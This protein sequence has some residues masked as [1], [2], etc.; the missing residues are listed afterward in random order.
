MPGDAEC[1]FV[2]AFSWVSVSQSAVAH[3]FMR[4][5]VACMWVFWETGCPDI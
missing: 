3:S 4:R 2:R 1:G 5:Q